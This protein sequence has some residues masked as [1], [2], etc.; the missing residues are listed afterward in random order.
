[1]SVP[2]SSSPRSS[3]L[4]GPD[5]RWR[6]A[7][8]GNLTRF[9][10]HRT[11]STVEYW[12]LD[13]AGEPTVARDRRRRRD[14]RAGPLPVVRRR[15]HRRARASPGGVV[16]DGVTDPRRAVE[17]AGEPRARCR[18]AGGA[19]RCRRAGVADR[20][21]YAS[22]WS[23]WPRTRWAGCPPTR[24]RLRCARW[25]GSPRPAGP[26]RAARRWPR[27][28]R[29]TRSSGSGWARG[30]A[31]RHRTW[32]PLSRRAARRRRPILSTSPRPRTWCVRRGGPGW[33]W[34]RSATSWRSRSTAASPS[35]RRRS[36]GSRDG[37][38][39]RAAAADDAAASAVAEAQRLRAELA[40]ARRRVRELE[41]DLGRARSAAAA[42]TADA[43]RSVAEAD[44][45]A[46]AASAQGRRLQSRVAELEAALDV[47]RRTGRG[48]R[49]HDDVRLRLLLDTLLGAAQGLRQELALPPADRIGDR[50]ADRVAASAACP[51]AGRT[52]RR[53]RPGQGARPGRPWPA[54]PAPGAARQPTS[55]STATT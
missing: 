38:A 19:A 14:G 43:E 34:R 13:L 28:S 42:A 39:T 36:S 53:R 17:V 5:T 55:S 3:S 11:R 24:S 31:S 6:C 41:A 10:V 51:G 22:G 20:P 44:S 1:M 33:S 49:G 15:R 16:G 23:P 2:P 25:P 26:G 50:P 46:A 30:C 4:P 27:R 45:T 35:S 54:R 47:A 12:H 37:C 29:P 21:R 9:D 32:S 52:R 48:E 7:R 8:C 18:R 40:E